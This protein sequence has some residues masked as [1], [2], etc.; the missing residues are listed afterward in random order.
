M[1]QWKRLFELADSLQTLKPWNFIYEGDIFGIR[2]PGTGRLGF[3]SFMGSG[4]EHYAMT[5][6]LGERALV[7]FFE[8]SEHPDLPPEKILEIPQLQVS[9]ENREFLEK[10]DRDL[11]RELGRKYAGK[12]AWPM[13][14]SFRPGMLPWFMDD[15]EKQAMICYLEQALDVVARPD[16]KSLL[17]SEQDDRF[18]FLV[19][20]Y[21]LTGGSPAWK[22]T[23]QRVLSLPPVEIQYTLSPN[24]IREVANLPAQGLILEAD[25]FMSPAQ[26]RSPG[27][28]PFFSY[29]LLV[30]D[31]KSE[32]VVG[33]ELL[34]PSGGLESMY[35]NV[36]NL[37]LSVLKG[38]KFRPREIHV[39][40]EVLSTLGTSIS[41]EINVLVKRKPRLPVLAIAKRELLGYLRSKR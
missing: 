38:M 1:D 25:L 5:V 32:M 6:Y 41:G 14:R 17:Q 34:D 33:Y 31:K 30:V 9:F 24:L 37:L 4:G 13:F 35:S 27:G 18:A 23:F 26:V 12:G 3:I 10:A 16:A 20:D 22:D 39:V 8:L 19:R 40:S 2:D 21:E 11:I 15:A 29:M 7:K 36:P 28:R